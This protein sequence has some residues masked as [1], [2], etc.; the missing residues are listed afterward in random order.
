MFWCIMGA[1]RD[2]LAPIPLRSTTSL[3]KDED[4][5]DRKNRKIKQCPKKKK[6]RW[7]DND[8]QYDTKD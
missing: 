4:S 7:T 6:D 8:L 5:K 1:L 3:R 2:S